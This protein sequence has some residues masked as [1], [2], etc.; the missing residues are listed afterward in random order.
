M[1][2]VVGRVVIRETRTGLARVIVAAYAVTTG[3]EPGHGAEYRRRLG[4]TITEIDGQ[5]ALEYQVPA[6]MRGDWSLVITVSAADEST[7]R[8]EPLASSARDNPAA[9]ESF[10]IHVAMAHL[11]EAGVVREPTPP[12]PHAVI[13]RATTSRQ[14]HTVLAAERRRLLA[15]QLAGAREVRRAAEIHFGRFMRS[16]SEADGE[17]PNARY[18][19][20]GASVHEASIA[21]VRDEVHQHINQTSVA[22]VGSFTDEDLAALRQQYGETLSRV[23]SSAVEVLLARGRKKPITLMR[24][25]PK[26]FCRRPVNDCVAILDP[27]HVP[28]EPDEPDEPGEPAEPAE[29]G[30]AT[31]PDLIARLTATMTSPEEKVLFGVRPSIGDVQGSVDGFALRSGPADV[32][33]TYD[34]HRLEI[35]FEPVWQELFDKG[36]LDTGRQLYE[37]FVELGLDP[38]EYLLGPDEKFSPQITL[39]LLPGGSTEQ[40]P[41]PD[42]TQLF[43]ITQREWAALDVTHQ[44]RLVQLAEDMAELVKST[45]ILD[46]VLSNI[47]VYGPLIEQLLRLYR[48]DADRD[49]NEIRV[50]AARIVRYAKE[51]LQA[52]RDFDQFHALL[53]QLGKSMKQPY[54]FSV[55]AAGRRERSVNFGVVVTYRQHWT[56]VT[57][58]VGELVRTVPLAP[59]EVRKYTRKVVRKL[60]RA[61]KEARSSLESLRTETSVTARIEAEIIAKANTK[62][63]FQVGADAGVSLEVVDFKAST[64]FGQDSEQS[65]QETKKEFRE[66]VFKAVAEY[67]SEHKLDVEVSESTE[68]TDEESGEISNP[69]DELPVTY[70]FYGNC[71]STPP[72]SRGRSVSRG[73]VN[74]PAQW[75][76]TI[77]VA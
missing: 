25:D 55:Y 52:P 28:D 38:N 20:P 50:K 43:E 49:A 42:V 24:L 70:L 56:P 69:N 9:K 23:P 37:K 8:N 10:Q 26:W 17:R 22:T 63:N 58:Q 75:N 29:P 54:R 68:F 2:T 31:V 34:F 47:P 35:A 72:E 33:A 18:V 3:A 11:I 21:A 51:K 6:E 57:Y 5:F 53:D 14:F 7:G 13:E 16:L 44:E 12:D 15:E 30:P 65:S 41:P 32:P 61:E 39:D 27:D 71:T 74:L 59:K 76:A 40:I 77:W 48:E 67:R 45:K 1:N 66:S 60:S 64:K 4:S 19:A 46:K 73:S 36:T 62:T